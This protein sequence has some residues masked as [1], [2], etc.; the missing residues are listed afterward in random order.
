MRRRR[1]YTYHFSKMYDFH[2]FP[3]YKSFYEIFRMRVQRQ[4]WALQDFRFPRE[5]LSFKGGFFS[6]LMKRIHLLLREDKFHL[7]NFFDFYI[8]RFRSLN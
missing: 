4:M 6:S 1:Y 3:N 7:V 2:R 8:K 5:S